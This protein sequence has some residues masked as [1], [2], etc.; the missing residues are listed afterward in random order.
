MASV[1]QLVQA[2]TDDLVELRRDFHAFPELAYKERRTASRIAARLRELGLDEV[3]EG[4]G[5]TGVVGRLRGRGDGRVVA[6]RADIDALPLQEE[7]SA[8]YASRHPGVMHACGHDGHTAI[9]LTAARVLTELREQFDGEVRFIFQPAE[10]LGNGA[11]GMLTDGALA[12]PRPQAVF[13]LHLWNNLPTGIVGVRDGPLFANT[14]EIDIIIRGAG[15]HGAMPHQTVDPIVIAAQVVTALQTM[16]SRETAP[17]EPAVVSICSIHGGTAF[18]IIPPEVHLL[19][20]V[21][22]F[23][24]ELQAQMKRRIGDL[25]QGIARSMGGDCDYVYRSPCPAVVNDP[26]ASG[27]VRRV[28]TRAFGAERVT[29]PAQT[30]GGD[31]MSFFLRE[32]P[33]SYVFLGTANPSLRSVAPHHHPKFDIDEA[34]LPVGARLLS[35]VALEFLGS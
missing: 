33:G 2:A 26:A 8:P 10:E 24:D 4:V 12:E 27:L 35:E 14:D 1:E 5:Q 21:R 16:V 29:T 32:V 19:G 6:L 3:R 34:A 7:S 30:M 11:P 15:G 23:T 22:T 20:T 9:L 31:D 13:G 28:A 25:V 18:N 17:S